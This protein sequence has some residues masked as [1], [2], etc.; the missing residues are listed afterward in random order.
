MANACS[1]CGAILADTDVLY[2]ADARITCAQCFAKADLLETDKRAGQGIKAAAFSAF[3]LALLSLVFN[4]FFICNL[5]SAITAVGVIASLF[6]K[7]DERFTK[8]IASW[9]PFLLVICAVVLL[10][11]AYVL[12]AII[13]FGRAVAGQGVRPHY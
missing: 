11:D 13:Q 12:Y 8:H 7:G 3:G 9:K 4:P 10:W 1:G 2:T 6:R 5:G